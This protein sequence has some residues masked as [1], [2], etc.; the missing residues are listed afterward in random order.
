MFMGE[1]QHTIDSKGRMIIPAKFRDG[2][3]EQFVLTRGLDQCLFGYPMSEWKLIEEKLKALPL[4][5][6]DARAFTRFFFSGAVECDLDK[7]GR[8]NIASNL[9]QYAKLEKE[10]VVIGVS[11]R[12]ELWSK[13][14]WEQ[15]TEEQ[16][17]S[18]AEIAENMIG[19]DI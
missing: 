2:L 12:I 6:K 13:S 15:Y 18:F 7:Q 17:D 3:G 9:L 8:I 10:C 14:I 4:T 19:F 5:K 1:Y 11:N 16:E